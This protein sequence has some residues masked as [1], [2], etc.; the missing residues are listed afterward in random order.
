MNRQKQ[1]VLFLGKKNDPYVEKALKFCQSNFYEVHS[2][3]GN[4]GDPLPE[5]IGWWDGDYIISYLSRWIV[6]DSL[7]QKAKIG[8][9][10]FHPAPPEF[11]GFGPNNFALYEGAQEY[12]VTCH[13]MAAQVDTGE[14][15]A[16]KRFPLLPTDDINTLLMRTYDY[17]LVLF[18][19][20]M[21]L[22]LQ[23]KD[24]PKSQ[25]SWTRKPFTRKELDA[26]GVI[27]PDMSREE[28]SRRIKSTSFQG[29][30]PTIELH[31]YVF[32]FKKDTGNST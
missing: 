7:L 14:I 18:Y 11:P 31:G 8:A 26:L 2:H 17:Q 30:K 21:G 1:A 5:G 23:G 22:I 6:P 32:E 3:L 25:D 13:R 28:I 10:N 20:I 24:L 29:W 12:G 27:T 16:V 9:I 19:D 4:W 15:I